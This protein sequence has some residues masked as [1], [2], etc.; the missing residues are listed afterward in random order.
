ML[1][2]CAFEVTIFAG[3]TIAAFEGAGKLAACKIYSHCVEGGTPLSV[4]FKLAELLVIFETVKF[5]GAKHPGAG[6]QT[7]LAFHPAKLTLPSLQ[8]LKVKQPVLLVAI[9][10]CP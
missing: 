2:T 10:V 7:I 4:Q 6:I 5:D 9:M 8:N 1:A 3:F